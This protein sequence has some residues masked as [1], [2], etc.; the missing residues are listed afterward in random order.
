MI[1]ERW[2][3]R[4]EERLKRTPLFSAMS[5]ISPDILTGLGVLVS[6][7]GAW[8]FAI[9]WFLTGGLLVMFGGF[10]DLFDGVVARHRGETTTF[11]GLLDSVADR[12]VDIAVFSAIGFHYATRSEFFWLAIAGIGLAGS[13]LVSYIKARGENDVPE[14]GVGWFERGERIGLLVAGGILGAMPV[15][16][17]VVALGSWWTAG[18]RLMLAR[19][20]MRELDRARE[21]TGGDRP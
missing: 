2:T 16:L 10:F 13:V 7:V 12:L 8:A 19:D 6:L 14:L 21:G 20:K 15:A 1:K 9:G 17:S 5:G 11:G 18:Q 3:D 4:A